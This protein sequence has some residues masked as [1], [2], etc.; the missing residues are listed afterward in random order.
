MHCRTC[1]GVRGQLIGVIS[2]LSPY[3]SLE[4]NAGD[5]AWRHEVDPLSIYGTQHQLFYFQLLV[6]A[7]LET[8]D[9]ADVLQMPN[10]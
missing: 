7:G 3:G 5:Q 10:H 6:I 4:L 1:V 8:Q 9:S 2:F